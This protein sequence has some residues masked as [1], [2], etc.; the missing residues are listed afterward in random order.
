[1]PYYTMISIEPVHYSSISRCF[2]F[3]AIRNPAG[4][5]VLLIAT[6]SIHEAQ[7]LNKK[8]FHNGRKM[9]EDQKEQ[10]RKMEHGR[11]SWQP[12]S[13]LGCGSPRDIGPQ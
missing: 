4:R 12:C 7:Q 1:M 10:M 9:A 3:W 13:S 11:K 6:S 2:F 5:W 8:T